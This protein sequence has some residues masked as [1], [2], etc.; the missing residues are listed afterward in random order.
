MLSMCTPAS[1][2]HNYQRPDASLIS[3][4]SDQGVTDI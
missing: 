1:L 2:R 3:D 4:A